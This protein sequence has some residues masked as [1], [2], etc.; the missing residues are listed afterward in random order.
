[1]TVEWLNSI[2]PFVAGL[3]GAGATAFGAWVLRANTREQ[4]QVDYWQKLVESQGERLQVLTERMA[5]LESKQSELERELMVHRSKY[6]VALDYIRAIL[7]WGHSLLLGHAS[8]PEPVA[9]ESIREDLFPQPEV[10]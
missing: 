6:W 7:A 4:T 10:E 8:L 3:S 9:P 5:R 2:N 1:M